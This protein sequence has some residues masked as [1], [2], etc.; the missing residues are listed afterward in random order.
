MRIEI[1]CSYLLYVAVSSLTTVSRVFSNSM[2]TC[3]TLM[4]VKAILL[5]DKESGQIIIHSFVHA[6]GEHNKNKL[7]TF[8]SSRLGKMMIVRTPKA[9]GVTVLR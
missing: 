7:F 5:V 2:V 4:H 8:C 1:V 3:Y 6:Y 9:D